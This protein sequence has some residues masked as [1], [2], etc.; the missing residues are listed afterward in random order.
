MRLSH[1]F[2][3]AVGALATALV[4]SLFSRQSHPRSRAPARVSADPRFEEFFGRLDDLE[5]RAEAPQPPP[6]LNELRARLDALES[7]V[8]EE[9]QAQVVED[10][11]TYPGRSN[12]ARIRAVLLGTVPDDAERALAA[13]TEVA[14][15]TADPERQA[16]AYFEIGELYLKLK[17]AKAAAT[18]YRRVVDRI[19]L[20]S[21]RG[22]VAA[23]HLGLCEYWSKD[24]VAAYQTFRRLADA[25]SLMHSTAPTIRYWAATL[26]AETGDTEYAREELR[27]FVDDYDGDGYE[28]FDRSV[29][30]AR[31][32]LKELE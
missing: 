19:G 12:A 6:P 22:Q 13:W 25:P 21:A 5:A 27:R 11:G 15:S 8:A 18:A 28:A 7:Q 9:R 32:I 29:R 1:V 23:H 26:A 4:M 17:D 31:R 2:C 20:G 30:N 16:D 14:E 3:I 24:H 10:V